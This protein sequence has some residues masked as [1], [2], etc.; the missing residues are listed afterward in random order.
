VA[1]PNRPEEGGEQVAVR[2]V[3]LEE[4]DAEAVRARRRASPR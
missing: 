1:A 3:Q 2:A 4:L